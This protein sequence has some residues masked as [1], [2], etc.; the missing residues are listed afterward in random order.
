MASFKEQIFAIRVVGSYV[1]CNGVA[2]AIDVTINGDQRLLD[3][4]VLNVQLKPRFS[5]LVTRMFQAM[6]VSV[7]VWVVGRALD[8][9]PFTPLLQLAADRIA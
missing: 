7:V 2:R 4:L 3:K 5:N 1:D 6:V 8:T 9:L